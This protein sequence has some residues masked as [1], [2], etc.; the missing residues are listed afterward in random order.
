VADRIGPAGRPL[1]D[2]R[3]NYRRQ[4]K[5]MKKA[6]QRT[7]T[8]EG[9]RLTL[10]RETLRELDT[11]ALPKIG[12]GATYRCHSGTNASFCC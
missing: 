7:T 9:F 2:P 6:A 11:A 10:H 3:R 4:E 5:T 12:G 1:G 8:Q